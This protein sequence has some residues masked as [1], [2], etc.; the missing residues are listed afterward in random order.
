MTA[1]PYPTSYRDLLTAFDGSGGYRPLDALVVPASRSAEHLRSAAALAHKTDAELLVLCSRNAEPALV[2]RLMAEEH[3][4][5]HH[6][7]HMRPG[8]DCRLLPSA[9]APTNLVELASRPELS[10]KRNLGLLVARMV[11]WRTVL[12]LDDD[13]TLDV[14]D[15]VSAQHGL[16]AAAAVGFPIDDWPDNSVVDHANRASGA[17]QDVFV[18]PSA[19]LV[20]MESA[21]L[22]HFPT[23]YDEG[24]LFLFDTV[25]ERRLSRYPGRARQLPYD[26]FREFDRG[27]D[28][29]FGEVIVEGLLGFLQA[30]TVDAC[31]TGRRYWHG[32]LPR[33]QAFLRELA[34]RLR[35]AAPSP[36]QVSALGA[37]HSAIR[38]HA[39]IT[40][41]ACAEF[42]RHWRA[43]RDRWA[44]RLDR[45]GSEP[46]VP[47]A[48]AR[49]GLSAVSGPPPRPR[50]IACADRRPVAPATA[51]AIAPRV[52]AVPDAE[53]LAVLVPGFLDSASW[54]GTR[55]LAGDLHRTGRTAVS[56]DPRGTFRTPGAVDQV[57]PSIQIRD[58]ISAIGMVRPHARTV[59]IGHSLGASIAVCAAAEDP[60]VTDVVAIMPPRCFVWP[61][62]FDP[63]RNT[64]RRVR[65]LVVATPG[66]TVQWQFKV[67]PAVVAD[68]VGHDLPARLRA[69]PAHQ[70][71]LFIA[72]R[73]DTVI[74]VSA[75]KR[76]FGEC[77]SRDKS[78]AI[79]PV[80]HDYRDHPDQLRQVNDA[81]LSWL[82][83]G[84]AQR[85]QVA[86]ATRPA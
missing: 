5:R 34:G 51:P 50:L 25:A 39:Q 36:R 85:A 67:P 72:G 33:R 7:V 69:M 58:A 38:R 42:V 52:Q 53:T 55:S 76:L 59:F 37:V 56:F 57:R 71:I 22:G 6:V 17:E 16:E 45:V 21:P 3:V 40:P 77:S 62:D 41:N 19:L 75:V 78:L 28:E 63:A 24:A 20:D 32:F 48:L 4:A 80:G 29:E 11:G 13:I 2:A 74:P 46:T 82:A 14:A 23:I 66:S 49:L 30:P 27:R 47:R 1:A 84:D 86:A 26:P 44:Q 60:R 43:E 65:R 10:R 31:P 61:H 9:P 79:L 54:A 8:Y 12:F 18:G 68:A 35:A 83:A 64:W 15:L 81:V 73:D 70:R